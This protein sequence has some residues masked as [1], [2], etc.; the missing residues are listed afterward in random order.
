[1]NN[2]MYKKNDLKKKNINIKPGESGRYAQP[3]FPG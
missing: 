3:G 1:M 2:K